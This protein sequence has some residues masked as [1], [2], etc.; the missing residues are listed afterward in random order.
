MSNN[1]GAFTLAEVLITLG[2]IGIVAAITLPL[3]ITRNQNKALETSLKKNYSEILQAL[4]MYQAQHSER[5]T[6]KV[7]PYK[8]KNEIIK[9]LKVIRDCG[10]GAQEKACI[11]FFHTD[12]D[13]SFK[14]YKTYSNQ[15][16]TEL[17][18]FD[19]GQL[20]LMDGSLV[21]IENAPPSYNNSKV[22]ITVDVNGYLKN[23]NR[24]GYDLFTFELDEKGNLLPM[25]TDGTTYT[26]E[27]AYCSINSTHIYNGIACTYKALT[28]KNYF[29]NLPK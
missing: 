18:F 15:E 27:S 11:P 20:V 5:L 21:L 6:S 29:T 22:F 14:L 1:K 12:P 2:I 23:P 8:F 16:L 26:N 24:W 3:V 19:D 9:Y 7:E 25:G 28:D 10:K 4:D 13:K 17:N